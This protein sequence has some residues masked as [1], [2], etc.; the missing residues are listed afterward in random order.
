MKRS[1]RC[2]LTVTLLGAITGQVPQ[3]PA[4]DA[5]PL[6]QDASLTGDD[7]P[8]IINSGHDFAVMSWRDRGGQPI[9]H[10]IFAARWDK[11]FVARQAPDISGA[12]TIDGETFDVCTRRDGVL[13]EGR[14][15]AYLHSRNGGFSALAL[16]RWDT[17]QGGYAGV[18]L[19]SNDT[20]VSGPMLLYAHRDGWLRIR[21]GAFYLRPDQFA[22]VP[23]RTAELLSSV[24]SRAVE[25]ACDLLPARPHDAQPAAPDLTGNYVSNYNESIGVCTHNGSLVAAFSGLGYQQGFVVGRWVAER[26]QWEGTVAEIGSVRPFAWHGPPGVLQGVW[27]AYNRTNVPVDNTTVL[28]AWAARRDDAGIE[29]LPHA[30]A[31]GHL[32]ISHLCTLLVAADSGQRAD[33]STP[34]EE[35]WLTANPS[36][37]LPPGMGGALFETPRFPSDCVNVT[38]AWTGNESVVCTQRAGPYDRNDFYRRAPEEQRYGWH[39][40]EIALEDAGNGSQ[41]V[42]APLAIGSTYIFRVAAIYVGVPPPPPP[43]TYEQR[44]SA[45]REAELPALLRSPLPPPPPPPPPLLGAFSAYSRPLSIHI[46]GP[47]APIGL[48]IDEVQ[49]T[50]LRLTWQP[51]P[52]DRT[53]GVWHAD[54]GAPILGYR[55]FVRAADTEAFELVASTP[56]PGLLLT[57]LRPQTLLR[58]RVGIENRVRTGLNSSTLSVA[59]TA[60]RATLYPDCGHRSAYHQP[61]SYQG[62]FRDDAAA[63]DMPASRALP[64]FSRV[65]SAQACAEACGEASR[66]FG[67]R[68]GGH[69]A[70]AD[71]FGRY[72]ATEDDE[73]DTPCTAE[74]TRMCGGANRTSVYRPA[75]LHGVLVGAGSYFTYDLLRARLPKSS[76]SSFELPEGL[77]LTLHT[78][79]ALR[80]LSANFTSSEACL[81]RVRCPVDPRHATWAEPAERCAADAWDDQTASLTISYAGL[82]PAYTPRPY[83]ET[84]ARAFL[85]STAGAL[86]RLYD[87]GGDVSETTADRQAAIAAGDAAGG[88]A[89][90]YWRAP[91]L[92]DSSAC[93]RRVGGYSSD[94]IC[95]QPERIEPPKGEPRRNPFYLTDLLMRA[96]LQATYSEEYGRRMRAEWEVTLRDAYA[97]PLYDARVAAGLPDAAVAYEAWFDTWLAGV[98]H[99]RTMLSVGEE[100]EPPALGFNALGEPVPAA[101]AAVPPMP[102]HPFPL[103]EEALAG[104]DPVPYPDAEAAG[105]V[106]R[107]PAGPVHAKAPPYE[108]PRLEIRRELSHD[109][110]ADTDFVGQDN[111]TL[112]VEIEEATKDEEPLFGH[113]R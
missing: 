60:L 68:A 78:R 10:R 44:L 13:G 38:D 106:A 70:C 32:S 30:L 24:P 101:D 83:G 11:A 80:G 55:V 49:P 84:G 95:L 36:A 7:A 56:T 17:V 8:R 110:D 29:P 2:M 100:G 52:F 64:G 34:S 53:A 14:L 62:C 79:D 75:G 26:Q 69:C 71:S 4:I 89:S 22:Y 25:L 6:R 42:V 85:R 82:Q 5:P 97:R 28:D 90:A 111:A 76:L 58:I 40:D 73:C 93:A 99:M 20:S 88:G 59:T 91:R 113:F 12:Y 16:A 105:G 33:H 18:L 41:A 45:E 63:P 103:A 37:E 61:L 50:S 19:H 67:L 104:A 108:T 3:Q 35:E 72:G 54:G 46:S 81:A 94:N 9:G 15:A 23:S 66:F 27:E 96:E 57:G 86:S 47:G 39:M 65:M 77:V 48:E 74:P 112:R 92:G 102:P 1:L 31:A 107:V 109:A 98:R 43:L 21:N 51:P 87:L